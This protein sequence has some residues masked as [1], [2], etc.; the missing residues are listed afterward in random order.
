MST[1]SGLDLTESF[2]RGLAQPEGSYRFGEDALLLGS[3]SARVLDNWIERKKTRPERV[4][5]AE[6]GSG[7]GAALFAL[8]RMIPEARG[9]GLEREPAL[10][11]AARANA[12]SLRLQERLDFRLFKIGEDQVSEPGAY[13]LVMSNPPWRKIGTGRETSSR[14][15]RI[16]MTR[17]DNRAFY[18]CAAELL[19]SRGFFCLILPMA[20]FCEFCADIK[21]TALGVR[22]VAPLAS[23]A[24]RNPD[25]VLICCQKQASSDPV[26]QFPIILYDKIDGKPVPT[27]VA[28]SLFPT[29]NA[30][31][32]ERT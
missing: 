28:L 31:N 2:P 19:V 13:R 17:S 6:L 5:V 12:V 16:A 23:F 10:V 15:R 8:S 25:R 14:L 22:N 20:D 30:R 9:L 4:K 3:W 32:T 18:K 1:N 7:C 21:G 29:L 11:E 27:S 24:D 26:F